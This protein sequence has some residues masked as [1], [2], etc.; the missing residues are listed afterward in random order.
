MLM[1]QDTLQ[2]FT[3]LMYYDSVYQKKDQDGCFPMNMQDFA[4]FIE[5]PIQTVLVVLREL[6][7]HGIIYAESLAQ[8][9]GKGWHRYR[10]NTET[11]GRYDGIKNSELKNHR[12]RIPSTDGNSQAVHVEKDREELQVESMTDKE[13]EFVEENPELRDILFGT[14]EPK[15]KPV[16]RTINDVKDYNGKRPQLDVKYFIGKIPDVIDDDTEYM[17][18]C[19]A[20]IYMLNGV[21]NWTDFLLHAGRLN[22]IQIAAQK[23]YS[24]E[25]IETRGTKVTRAQMK[26]TVEC[27]QKARK[28]KY[29]YFRVKYSHL[30]D[31]GFHD[32]YEKLN[33]VPM[34]M[35]T[36]RERMEA[37]CEEWKNR[38]RK[39]EN[40]VPWTANGKLYDDEDDISAKEVEEIETTVNS[41]KFNVNGAR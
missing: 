11:F 20:A 8:T 41:V 36:Y 13:K 6:W 18:Y 27:F 33:I 39:G 23:S 38:G 26:R 40:N 31:M 37:Y 28:R 5:M 4:D 9:R 2:V 35:E 3:A 21:K 16:E 1:D 34:P 19:N 25:W 30:P 15:H 22:R 10:I 32:M 14:Y 29:K 24:D 12:I 7:R 17:R